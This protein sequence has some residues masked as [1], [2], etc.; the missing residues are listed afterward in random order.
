MLVFGLTN[1]FLKFTEED[2]PGTLLF[3]YSAVLTRT[4]GK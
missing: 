2:T 4:M 1:L 3:L